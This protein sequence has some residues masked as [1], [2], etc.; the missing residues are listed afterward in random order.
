[1]RK[2][3]CGLVLA[4]F[5]SSIAVAQ[6]RR[7][8]GQTVSTRSITIITEPKAKVWIDD[9]LR[10]STDENGRLEIKTAPPGVRRLRVRADGFK[11]TTQTLSA[12]QKGE[13]KIAL[14]KTTDEA[15]L[16]FQQA[17]NAASSDREK[18]AE[19][20]RKAIRLRPKYA[21]AYVGLARVLSDAGDNEGALKAV[22]EARK[23]RPIFPEISAV[24]GRIYRSEGDD[25]KAIASFRRAIREGRGYQPEAHTGLGLLYK[26]RAEAFAAEGDMEQEKANYDLAVK[27]LRTA[28][29]QLSGAPD[30]EIIYQLLGVAYEK[31]RKYREAIKVYEEFLR[32][33]PDSSEATAVRS[34][35]VQAQK[36]MNEQ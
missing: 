13:I 12:A 15:E 31:Q 19:L 28:I 1:M 35:I 30:A 23:I 6:P 3:F 9:V 22:A 18:S 29:T 24:E 8:A 2:I 4:F 33:F 11:E 16:A 34:F 27:E 20:Y 21:E 26:E 7:T 10:G 25:E 17:E 14:A 36:Q 5:C 32:F